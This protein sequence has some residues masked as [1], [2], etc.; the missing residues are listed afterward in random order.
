MR[1]RDD[2]A[3]D[4][5]KGIERWNKIIAQTG[6]EIPL[7]LPHVAFNRCIGEFKDVHASPGGKL[8]EAADV[9][10]RTATNGCLRPRRTATSSVA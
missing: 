7:R 2:Y 4:C 5:A 6:V 1:L 10:G 9:D 8:V 3:D